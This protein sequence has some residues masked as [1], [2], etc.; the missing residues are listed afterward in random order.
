[1][2]WHPEVLTCSAT[3]KV[4]VAEVYKMIEKFYNHQLTNGFFEKRRQ[5]QN[6]LAF[7]RLLQEALYKRLL[8]QEGLKN[9]IE[10]SEEE[11]KI[12][13]LSPYSAVLQLSKFL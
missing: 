6:L 7:Q 2:A 11:V 1:S 5:T 9:A 3:E 12:G 4:G 13:K 8:N 10:Q